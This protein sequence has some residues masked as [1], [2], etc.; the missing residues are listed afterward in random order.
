MVWFF[1]INWIA[2]FKNVFLF[3]AR[4]KAL[5]IVSTTI[6]WLNDKE[7]ELEQAFKPRDSK[8]VSTELV[9]NSKLKS[10]EFIKK[11]KKFLSESKEY[12]ELRKKLTRKI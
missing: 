12:Q 9:V 6:V 5:E 8:E 7:T 1:S 3:L 2:F 10:T 11:V 4:F